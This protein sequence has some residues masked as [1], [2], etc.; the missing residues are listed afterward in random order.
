MK[1]C[2][3][4]EARNQ[5]KSPLEVGLTNRMIDLIADSY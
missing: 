5:G 3:V 2:I 4:P 1:F